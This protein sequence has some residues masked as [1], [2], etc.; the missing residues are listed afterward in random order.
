[1]IIF[2][3]SEELK[4]SL[5]LMIAFFP[6]LWFSMYLLIIQ[7]QTLHQVLKSLLNTFSYTSYDFNDI[8]KSLL[9][10]F[11]TCSH[12]GWLPLCLPNSHPGLSLHHLTG[13]PA[14]SHTGR[15]SCLPHC[16]LLFL[17]LSIHLVEHT[18]QNF[19]RKGAW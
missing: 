14:I 9:E 18:L 3:F 15:I 13:I 7:S 4:F 10:C 19:L 2:A 6:L 17:G 5:E 1:M 16:V 12:L 8:L 11:L